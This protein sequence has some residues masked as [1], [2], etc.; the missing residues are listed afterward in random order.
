[1]PYISDTAFDAALNVL[2]SNVTTLYITSQEA[3]DYNGAS[4]TYKLGTKSTF[5]LASGNPRDGAVSGRRILTPAITDGSVD[6][7]GT[8]THWAL[9]SG[10]VLYATGQLSS[11]QAV[12]IGNTFTLAAFSITLPD[13]S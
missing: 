6:A 9:C 4:N 3:V 5:S 7:S 11:S 2:I 13:A 8:A 1:M 12:T 10:S